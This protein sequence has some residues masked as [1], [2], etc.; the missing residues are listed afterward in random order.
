LNEGSRTRADWLLLAGFCTFLFIF[1]LNYFGLIG[2]DEPRYAQ[3]AREM[4]AR[5]DW[6]TPTL[7]GKPWLEKPPL[8]YWQAMLAYSVFGVNDWA[9]RLPSA[10]DATGMIIAIYWFLLRFRRGVHLDGALIAASCAAVIGYARAASTDMPLAAALTVALLAWYAWHETGAKVYL[11]VSYVFVA[12]GTLA[13]GPVA[14]VLAAII[15]VIFA[16]A[17]RQWEL[18]RRSLWL[19]GLAIF[20][21]VALPWYLLV[22][23]RNPEF[24]R[25]FILQHNLARFGTNLYHHPQPFWFY[26]PVMLLGL[27][28]WTIFVS[29]ASYES[30]RA[31]WLGRRASPSS[32]E[33]LSVFCLIWLLVPVIFFSL[34]QSKLPGYILPSVPAGALLLSEYLR[35]RIAGQESAP[36]WFFALHSLVAAA[37]IVPALMI[38]YIL[39]Q[40]RF[41][42]GRG[43]IVAMCMAIAVAVG[44]AV[45]LSRTSGLPLLRFVT[46]VPVVLAVAAVLRIGGATLDATLSARPLAAELSSMDTKHLP[47][48]VLGVSRETDYGLTFYRDQVPAH[49]DLGQIPPGEHLLVAAEA[50]EPQI[51]KLIPDRRASHLG[52]FAAQHLDYYWISAPGMMP[53]RHH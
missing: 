2:A 33:D 8:Y 4:L 36:R 10:L 18:I 40:H 44:M 25:V 41:P 45:T 32:T 7:G 22:Q 9:A 12:L 13:K 17:R 51:E 31:W 28:P 3:V 50:A 42:W 21:L 37:P 49:Y 48:A 15:I 29:V 39:L 26:A 52:N 14:P 19:P 6:I 5:H 30:A 34:S 53:D 46:L 23:L 16:V 43:A 20:G 24:F 27:L 38:Q 35:R 11:A 47:L 1:G